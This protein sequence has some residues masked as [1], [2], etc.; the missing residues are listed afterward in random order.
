MLN[1]SQKYKNIIS[2]GRGDPDLPTPKYIID[3]TINKLMSGETGYTPPEGLLELRSA[4]VTK[5]NNDNNLNYNSSNII[6]TNGAQEA[7]FITLMIVM[8]APG[9]RME[10]K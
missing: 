5:L 9:L 10:E 8:A 4:I 2:L 7:I 3:E 6:V 1:L